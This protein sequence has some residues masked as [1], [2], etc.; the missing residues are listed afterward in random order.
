MSECAMDTI[1]RVYKDGDY[2]QI[3]PDG[4]SLGLVEIRVMDS[5]K[6]YCRFT[7]EKKQASLVARGIEKV[8]E[9]METAK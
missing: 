8:I 3:G 4:D 5:G 6:E 9:E 2:I 1:V 7:M